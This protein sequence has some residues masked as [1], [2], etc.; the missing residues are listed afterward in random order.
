MR[1]LGFLFVLSLLAVAPAFAQGNPSGEL[2]RARVESMNQ[3]LKGT[4]VLASDNSLRPGERNYDFVTIQKKTVEMNQ[5]IQTVDADIVQATKG[6]LSAD[7]SKRL[8]RIE[9][10]AKEIRQAFE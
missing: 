6:V 4:S 1:V 3:R 10:L 9:K 8:K 7:M 5:L 2:E